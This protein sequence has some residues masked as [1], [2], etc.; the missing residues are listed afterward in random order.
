MT[1]VKTK[2]SKRSTGEK[3]IKNHKL[4][5]LYILSQDTEKLWFNKKR[6]KKRY[7]YK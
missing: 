1:E 6:R 4:W 3:E 2:V 5:K 7:N